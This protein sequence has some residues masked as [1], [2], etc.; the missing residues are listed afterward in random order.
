MTSLCI[1]PTGNSPIKPVG[2]KWYQRQFDPYIQEE[3]K[4]VVQKI[5]SLS[6]GQIFG[7]AVSILGIVDLLKNLIF[8][9]ENQSFLS[10]LFMPVALFFLGGFNVAVTEPP[11]DRFRRDLF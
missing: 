1:Q 3:K 4:T 2:V 8:P 5:K 6:V 7:G 10:K 11:K 9:K